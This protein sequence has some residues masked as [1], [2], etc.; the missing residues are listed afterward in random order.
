MS[1]S[2]TQP[3]VTQPPT[4]LARRRPRVSDAETER[5]MLEAGV[6]MVNRTGLTVSLEHLSLEELISEARVS[7]SSVYRR[8]PYK[9]LFFSDLLRELAKAAT[10][11]TVATEDQ[12]LDALLEVVR[13]R[14]AWLESADGRDALILELIRV[15][16][17]HDYGLVRVS[18]AWRTYLA[19]QATF[20]SIVDTDLRAELQDNLSAADASFIERIAHS[21]ERL[22][23]IFGYRI[24][25]ETGLTFADVA[26]LLSADLR[27]HVLLSLAS[28][29][30][31]E[32]SVQ[33]RP[34]GARSGAS[35]TLPG[36]AAA[37]LAAACFEPDPAVTWD[38]DRAAAARSSLLALGQRPS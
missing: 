27:G 20:H 7:R 21:W 23:G 34:G 30:D 32:T 28:P 10:P 15:G 36:I 3:S 4:G 11:A 22:T 38:A 37:A 26:R 2:S 31:A 33:A 5:R 19:L 14:G 16:A 13:D 24:R 25:P 18:T 17:A 9:D 8:W 6:A 35:W 1:Q 12:A 29:G